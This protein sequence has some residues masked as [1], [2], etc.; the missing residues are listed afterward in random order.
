M[1]RLPKPFTCINT[2]NSVLQMLNSLV[3]FCI[4]LFVS[5]LMV[6]GCR[7]PR[8]RLCWDM[9]CS[10]LCDVF[11]LRRTKTLWGWSYEE[12]RSVRFV[13]LIQAIVLLNFCHGDSMCRN[14]NPRTL[15]IPSNCVP[16]ELNSFIL[17]VSRL[18]TIGCYRPMSLCWTRNVLLFVLSSTLRLKRKDE[19]EVSVGVIYGVASSLSLS[20][21]ICNPKTKWA[22][23]ELEGLWRL[24]PLLPFKG[25]TPWP[26]AD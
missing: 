23:Q 15:L 9:R 12:W 4:V 22:S 14:S 21:F 8:M 19:S 2:S 6:L 13:Y 10:S 5:P 1:C 7:Y 3:W 17:F 18:M 25:K 11:Y 20:K 24:L 26:G 16:H